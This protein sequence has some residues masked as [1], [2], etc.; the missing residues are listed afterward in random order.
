MSKHTFGLAS[1]KYG[2]VASDGDVAASFNEVGETVSGTCQVTSSDPQTT[3]FKIE[4]SDSPI[5]SVV[6]TPAELSL[7]FSTF[8]VD[9]D[10]LVALFGGTKTALTGV[11]ATLGAI[12]G[13]STYTNGTYRDVLL[14]GGAGSGARADITIAGGTVTAVTITEGGSGYVTTNPL[15][16]AAVNVGGT[17]SGFSVT[18]ATVTTGTKWEAPDSLPEMEKSWR[19]TDKKGNIMVIPRGKI[20]SKLNV[21][22]AKDKLG[23]LDLTVK[24][25]Q[26]AKAGVK[27]LQIVYGA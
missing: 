8:N 5:E 26:P 20:S 4:E 9:A 13:G 15:S 11:V 7:A 10:T 17:G 27:R 6:S 16:A 18:V 12:T 3:E 1:V 24:V 22:F 2:T 25:L 21:S 23:Q 19:L 14:T